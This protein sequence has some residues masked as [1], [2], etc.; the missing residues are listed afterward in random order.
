MYRVHP[1]PK[2]IIREKSPRHLSWNSPSHAMETYLPYFFPVHL[3]KNETNRSQMPRCFLIATP[4][5]ELAPCDAVDSELRSCPG[6]DGGGPNVSSPW[7]I[8]ASPSLECRVC[9]GTVPPG[10]I[11][12]N[13]PNAL[14]AP[15]P[16]FRCNEWSQLYNMPSQLI[17]NCLSPA[18]HR[19]L[20][21]YRTVVLSSNFRGPC[22][23]V[24]TL[25]LFFVG[26][27]GD[28]NDRKWTNRTEAAW[29]FREIA[30]P[31]WKKV[32]SLDRAET[33]PVLLT[34]K[35]K[36]Q[37]PIICARDERKQKDEDRCWTREK[38]LKRKTPSNAPVSL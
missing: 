28:V 1:L 8:R 37:R 22:V 31:L 23:S 26:H 18:D 21:E 2:M 6:I 4:N 32:P 15:A 36:R 17:I 5:C 19:M 13:S 29:P 35:R 25:V 3:S 20:R 7:A 38:A 24:C 11:S 34:S 27:A 10:L 9:P 30:S 14:D 33:R 12:N 16:N